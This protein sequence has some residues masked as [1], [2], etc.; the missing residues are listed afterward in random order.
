MDTCV[1]LRRH[2]TQGLEKKGYEGGET[3]FTSPVPIGTTTTSTLQ[4]T[5]REEMPPQ[6]LADLLLELYFKELSFLFPIILEADVRSIRDRLLHEESANC[7]AA[8]I[9]FS[10]LAVAAPLIPTIHPIFD[11]VSL[12]YRDG[13]MG[14]SFYNLAFYFANSSAG[15]K[16]ERRGK[17]QDIVLSLGLLSIYL[18]ETGSQAES[19]IMV[20]RAI[21]LGQDLGLHRSPER[22]HLPW[23]ERSK[24]RYLWWCLYVLERQLSIA[25]G[26]PLSID[27]ADCDVE[28]PSGS[29][30]GKHCE[31]TEGFISMIHLH[32]ILGVILKTVNSVKNADSWREVKKYE[33]LRVRVRESNMALQTWAKDQV[34]LHIKNAKSGM[35]LT[36]KHIALSSFFSGVILLHRVYM[37]NPHRPSPLENSQAQ[38]RSG[39]AAT[40]CIRGTPDFLRCVPKCHYLVFHGQYVF[41]SAIVLLQCVRSSD[42]MSYIDSNLKYVELAL[43]SLRS[44]DESWKGAR[45]CHGIVEEYLEFT[46]H[47]LESDKKGVCNFPHDCDS[48][49]RKEQSR[50]SR[51]TFTDRRKDKTSGMLRSAKRVPS[52]QSLPPAHTRNSGVERLS[53]RRKYHHDAQLP[54]PNTDFDERVANCSPRLTHPTVSYTAPRAFEHRDQSWQAQQ[55]MGISAAGLKPIGDMPGT[56]FDDMIG[57]LLGVI[58]DEIPVPLQQ[59]PFF[60]GFSLDY[61]NDG[62]MPSFCPEALGFQ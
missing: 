62:E 36:Q 39:K 34:P 50:G 26:R 22:L 48:D 38:Q 28:V 21:R 5:L 11:D 44:L 33:E 46:L 56:H 7:G 59:D 3:F 6:T 30:D 40:D 25:L 45:K 20:G 54:S 14:T 4:N 47:V 15:E 12:K 57:N 35:L 24:R 29:N 55:S 37:S 19:W 49:H 10:V 13:D 41:V 58:P 61:F 9:F 42:D 43:E 23:Q 51:T 27:D 53:K 1:G 52:K 32:K 2:I 60:S 18:A 31:G 17:S 16:V 8:A